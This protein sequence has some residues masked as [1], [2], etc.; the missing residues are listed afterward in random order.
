MAPCARPFEWDLRVGQVLPAP[1]VLSG[2]ELTIPTINVKEFE[3]RCASGTEV[4]VQKSKE[5]FPL[6]LPRS[7]VCSPVLQVSLVV[8]GP[9]E[10]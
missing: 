7:R 3:A 5:M 2:K 1:E 9:R 6:A 4:A 8:A 10:P